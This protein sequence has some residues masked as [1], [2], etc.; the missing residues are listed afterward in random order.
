MKT[1]NRIKE[2]HRMVMS[3]VTEHTKV[4]CIVSPTGTCRVKFFSIC[5]EGETENQRR[6]IILRVIYIK[7][8]PFKALGTSQKKGRKNVRARICGRQL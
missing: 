2:E 4:V 6:L 8:L 1:A 5:G 3:R 7:L